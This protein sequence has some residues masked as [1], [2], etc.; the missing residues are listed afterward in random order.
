MGVDGLELISA[1]K[2][3]KKRGCAPALI[4]QW[5]REGRLKD[6][7]EKAP[8]GWRWLIDADKADAILDSSLDPGQRKQPDVDTSGEP[9]FRDARALKELYAAKLKRLEYEKKRKTLVEVEDV[10]QEYFQEARA[11]RD[12]FLQIP[13]RLAA[14]L[15]TMT[16]EHEVYQTLRDELNAILARL[17]DA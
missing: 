7:A 2:Y 16:D 3:A 9:S 17:S 6:A 1:T 15:A 4:S 14:S 11:L 10:K 8:D 12:A 13:D 5:C